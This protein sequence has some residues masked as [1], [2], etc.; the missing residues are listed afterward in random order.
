MDKF[1]TALFVL[2]GAL[3]FGTIVCLVI[4]F[5]VMLIWNWIMPIF[6][7]P[8]LTFMQSFGLLVLCNLLI[9]S[10]SESVSTK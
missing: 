2:I 5:P 8:E 1:L 10:T 6:K 7:L 3:L 4:A 9:K